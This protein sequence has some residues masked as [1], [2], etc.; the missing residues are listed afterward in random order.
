MIQF[1]CQIG[2]YLRCVYVLLGQPPLFDQQKRAP[3]Q[4]KYI[5]HE[6]DDQMTVNDQSRKA[7]MSIDQCRSIIEVPWDYAYVVDSR[8]N[9]LLVDCASQFL[10]TIYSIRYR[11]QT[12][13][14][15]MSMLVEINTV[16][17]REWVFKRIH[18]RIFGKCAPFPK[19]TMPQ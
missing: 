6:T 12:S 13:M 15:C 17:S 8:N 11:I 4:S 7:Y 1:A 18:F 9:S 10:A 3:Y 19:H 5:Q 16:L 2:H 14:C